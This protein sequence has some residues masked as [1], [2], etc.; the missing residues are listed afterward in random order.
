MKTLS[1]ITVT[2]DITGK[3]L[4]SYVAKNVYEAKRAKRLIES[5][6]YADIQVFV[7][8]EDFLA[9]GTAQEI[10]R[11]AVEAILQTSK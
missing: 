4:A 10:T 6:G 1:R 8:T 5:L 9:D 2:S 3:A 11:M 7:E